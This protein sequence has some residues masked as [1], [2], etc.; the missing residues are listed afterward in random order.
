MAEEPLLGQLKRGNGLRARHAGE[1]VQE[2]IEG[3][4]CFEIIEQRL[5][6]NPCAEKDRRTAKDVRVAVNDRRVDGHSGPPF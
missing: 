2:F 3:R 1:M 6:R 4:T 5:D